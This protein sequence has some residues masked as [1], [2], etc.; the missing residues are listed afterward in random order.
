MITKADIEKYF[1]AE[2]QESLLFVVIG[3]VALI[4]AAIGLFMYKTPFWKGASI[5][6]IAIALI[7]IGVGYGVYARSDK[8]RTDTVYLLD[9]NPSKLIKEEIPRMEVVNKN[10]VLY[11]WVEIILAIAGLTMFY[12]YRTN[13][14]KQ[15]WL[16]LG[17]ALAIQALIM[18]SADYFAEKRA[19]LYTQQLK[20][21]LK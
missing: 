11:R 9:M 10:F 5:P 8:Q 16:G 20:T 1:V 19:L 15:F 13:A 17:I 3:V 7:Q 12:L 18:L 6:L 14:D 2:K 21:L 4:V